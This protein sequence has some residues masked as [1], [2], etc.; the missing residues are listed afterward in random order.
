MKRNVATL[1]NIPISKLGSVKEATA[2][3]AMMITNIGLTIEAVTAAS[4]MSKAPT[5]PMV[6]P[7]G[8]G[9]RMPASLM[10]S[11]PKNMTKTST[12]SGKG[13]GSLD[14]AIAIIRADGTI[15]GW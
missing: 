2:V 14:A 1:M 12:K 15:S 11:N 8:E 3:T 5:M 13:M 9:I 10:S 4:P 6:G 7:I